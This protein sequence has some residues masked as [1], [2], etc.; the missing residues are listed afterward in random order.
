MINQALSQIKKHE[1]LRL[2]PYRC[3][4]GKLTI[5][6]GRNLDDV[7]I[8]DIE[9]GQ[10]LKNDLHICAA[11]L[12]TIFPGF[13]E[14][15]I[16]KQI[17]LIDMRFNLGPNRFRGFKK[18]IA[19]IKQDDWPKAAIEAMDS[20]WYDQVGNRGVVVINKLCNDE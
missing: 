11:D 1:G 15:A 9:A 17:A 10:L 7:G 3:T 12:L 19:A 2:K 16:S 8:S 5:G 4:A 18:M 13:I 14:F 6:Y 20:K